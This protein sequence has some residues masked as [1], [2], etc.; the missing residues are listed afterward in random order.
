[1]PFENI[2]L[3]IS[4]VAFLIILLAIVI[5]ILVRKLGISS[6]GPI[7]I[8]QRNLSTEYK[9]NEETREADDVCLKQI[10]QA[11][12]K[13]KL[14]IGNIFADLKICTL[15]RVAISLATRSPLY[16]SVANNH[17]T[18]ELM[19][20]NFKEYRERLISMIKEE[21]V[22]LS[23]ASKDIQCN[24]E[25]LPAWDH[26]SQHLIE[27]IDRWIKSVSREVMITC[28][29]KIAVYQTYL[30]SFAEMKDGWRTDIVKKCIEK[31]ERYIAVLKERTGIA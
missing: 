12:N 15:A 19:P 31:N 7:K 6:L 16:E 23:V 22:S 10:R 29:K 1:M 17:F 8:E 21:Y 5:I 14:G 26:I 9:M 27:Q 3:L 30:P 28:K 24:K 18:T 20:E 11:T 4:G 2:A 13:M 25:P